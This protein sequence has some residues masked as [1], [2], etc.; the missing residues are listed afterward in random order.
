[1]KVC[2]CLRVT[3]RMIIL[4]MF[5]GMT[6]TSFSQDEELPKWNGYLQT[7]MASDFDKST[8]FTIRRAKLWINGYMPKADF[9]NYKMQMVYRSFKDET[10]MLQ[11]AF[12][13]IRLNSFGSLRIGRFVPDFMLQRGQPDYEI[14]VLERATVINSLIHNEKQ[15]ARETGI[16]FT[17]QNAELPLHFSL[18]VFNANV[19]KPSHSKNDF[20]LYTSRLA[21]KIINNKNVWFNI[22][23]SASYRYLDKISLTTIYLPDSLIT[24]NDFRWGLETQ[25]H[26]GSFELQCEYV[27]ARINT[28]K[29]E[30]W[31]I[32][33]NYSFMKT[34]QVVAFAEK[35]SSLNPAANNNE[36]LGLGFN[37][38]ISGRTKLMTDIKTQKSYSK[39]NYLGEIQLQVFFN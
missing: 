9:I 10:L 33:T 36:W 3:L 23:G 6:F 2:L 38:Q 37:Y 8:E 13:D 17:F 21:Y 15:M 34:V 39:Q 32:L 18:G 30:G 28:D 31:Y 20:L 4:L 24:G 29:A 27:Q 16:Q 5:V 22:G 19:D 26:L 11:D 7:R 14:P 25:L 12:A 35:Y 1:M